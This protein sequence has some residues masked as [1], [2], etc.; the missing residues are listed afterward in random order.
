[1]TDLRYSVRALISTPAV[2][3]MVLLIL[4]LG[5]GATTAIVTVANAVL[6]RPLPFANP[7]RLVQ[8]GTI[9]VLEF[10]AYREQSRTFES[11]VSYTTVNKNL[12]DGAEPERIT[13]VA[14]EAGLFDLLGVAAVSGRTFSSDD[15]VNVAVVSESFWQRRSSG[16]ALH[17][18]A[19]V[20]DGEPFMV[21][22]VLPRSRSFPI[23]ASAADVWIPAPLP[24]TDNWFQRIDAAVG[25]LN[26]RITID[27]ARAELT[28]I[29]RRLEPLSN[30]NPGRSLSIVPLTDAVVGRSR[31]SV[32]TL[33]AAAAMVLLIACANV[34]NLLL[35]RA[36]TRRR[37]VA[38]RI[39]LGAGRRRLA[40]QFLTE[41]LLLATA[42]S[43][44]ALFVAF[45]CTRMLV[46]IGA[47]QIPRA[48]EIGLDWATVLFLIAIGG[49]TAVLFGLVPALHAMK[50]D[51][52]AVLNAVSSRTSAGRRTNG[53]SRTLVVSEV[54]LAFVLL[55]GAGLL[56]RAFVSLEHVPV[57][58]GGEHALTLR[59]ESRGLLPA[60]ADVIAPGQRTTAQG[61]YFRDIEERVVQIPGVRAAG[62]V[63][64]LHLQS[65]GNRGQFTIAG[66]PPASETGTTR[67]RDATPGYFRALGIPLRAGRFFTD[68]EPGILV[69][70]AFARAFF[71]GQDPIGRALNRGTIVGVVGD[72]RQ[73]LR[74]PAEPEIY[75][76][77]DRTTYS[78]ATLVVDADI[79]AESL[80]ASVRAAILD[81]NPNQ[82]VFDIRSMAAVRA[83]AHDDVDLSLAVIGSFAALAFILAVAGIYGVLSFAVTARRKEFGI[84]LALGAGG[85][86]VLGLVL[87]Q[88]G[89]MIVGGVALGI[90]GALTLTRFLRA[91][92][93]EVTPTDPVTFAGATLLLVSVA[94]IA[95]I[96]PAR[97]A[98]SVDPMTVLRQ[99]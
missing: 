31:T 85:G 6:L 54:A 16:R 80:V 1:M 89:V 50:P 17:D 46:T 76:P 78:A 77:L 12:R 48:A 21:I 66:A 81:I 72:V 30:S 5:I 24:R 96:Y 75:T 29:A 88:G 8:F 34:A 51:V 92:L 10:K 55:S 57:G 37:E 33:L 52:A 73:S 18:W 35:A 97:R 22:G 15:P 68:H 38:I 25:R 26:E 7:D 11:L 84:R 58:V 98:M 13:A 65:P 49:L 62:F 42:A 90:A 67:L 94:L 70:E 74:V 39:A 82:P 69:N 63:T 93:Y 53:V 4:A 32:L 64:R 20:L 45:A 79:S 59:I 41:S 3:L 9:G 40:R 83:G 56:L 71:P 91:L 47:T 2:T 27:A 14:A 28:S 19:I 43:A 23:S 36:E 44:T 60:Q 86:Q 87:A 95:C 99:D 61:R